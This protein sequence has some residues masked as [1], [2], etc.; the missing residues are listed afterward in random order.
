MKISKK[1][2]NIHTGDKYGNWLVLDEN[3]FEQKSGYKKILCQCQCKNK[4]V[5][6]VDERNLKNGSSNSCGNCFRNPLKTGETF[7]YWTIIEDES[8][9]EN[10][11]CKC[12]CGAI[13]KVNKK[14]LYNGV[15]TNCGCIGRNNH[16]AKNQYTGIGEKIIIGGKYNK[17]TVLKQ[18]KSNSFLCECSCFHH[19]HQILSRSTLLGDKRKGC[20]K[21]RLMKNH[22]GETYGYLTILSIDEETSKNKSRIYVYAKCKCGNI[23]SYEQQAIIKG[24]VVSC[25]CKKHEIDLSLIGKR[26][27][28]LT[29]NKLIGRKYSDEE[30]TNSFIEWECICDC[31]NK[32]IVRQ[33]NLLHGSTWSC[34]CM[35]R[36]HGEELIYKFLKNTHF[37]FKEQYRINDCKNILPLPF[38]FAILDEEQKLLGLIEFD[39]KQHFEPFQFNNCDINK[40]ISNYKNCVERDRIKTNYCKNHNIK[41]LR[42]TYEDLE[43][44]N[45]IYVLWDFLYDLN[46]IIDIKSAI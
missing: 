34:G 12:F 38:D 46:L 13:K 29:V 32:T 10:I 21:C 15:S 27:G 44:G 37:I 45:W 39:G 41:L 25:G 23:H 26:F 24:R 14:N 17:W 9:Y 11:L 30:C 6:Y 7:G 22:I 43:D 16:Y 28:Y 8:K 19:T 33:G 3:D 40:S 36:S 42:I 18:V 1:Y 2:N 20:K 4:T 5:K 31:G 35:K